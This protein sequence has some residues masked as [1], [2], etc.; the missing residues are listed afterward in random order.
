MQQHV[1]GVFGKL[2]KGQKKPNFTALSLHGVPAGSGK[3]GNVA[4]RKRRKLETSASS[5]I[6][7]LQAMDTWPSSSST[8]EVTTANASHIAQAGSSTVNISLDSQAGPSHAV[9]SPYHTPV[10]AWPSYYDWGY[11]P[12]FPPSCGYADSFNHHGD[13]TSKAPPTTTAS[14]GPPPMANDASPFNLHFISGNISKCVGCGNKYVKPAVPPYDLC[15]QHREWRSF[16]VGGV[17]Q[18]KFAPAYY[19][20]NTLCIQR[21]WPSFSPDQVSI[22]LEVSPRL[23]TVHKGYLFSHGIMM[24]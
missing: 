11:P 6:D 22:T 20:V 16:S 17:Q 4:P 12:Y 10:P 13:S 19:H 23:T 9:G 14:F 24:H 8:C 21:K 3:K 18:S 15:I 2:S 7:R 1:D 5:R